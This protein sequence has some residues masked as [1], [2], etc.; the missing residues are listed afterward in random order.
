MQSRR[1]RTPEDIR[2]TER[3]D[4][5]EDIS[6]WPNGRGENL[7]LRFRVG[8]LDL[9]ER[10]KRYTSSREEEDVDRQKCPC[11]KAMESRTHIVAECE[12][13][14]EERDV[15]EGEMRDMNEGGTESF[16]GLDSREKTIAILGDRWWPQTVK[17]E[18]DKICER[19]LGNVWKK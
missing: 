6:A 18:G 9:P 11:G 13:Y 5:D 10:R 12:L 4:R 8:D 1:G 19:F 14:K 15:L 16:E 3:G 7:K 2:G 17:Q